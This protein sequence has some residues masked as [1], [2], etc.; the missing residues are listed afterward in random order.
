MGYNFSHL[1][2]FPPQSQVVHYLRVRYQKE[3]VGS[4]H[5]LSEAY[6][7]AGWSYENDQPESL[8]FFCRV[9]NIGVGRCFLW[10]RSV[11]P[12]KNRIEVCLGAG[13]VGGRC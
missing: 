13:V 12:G 9:P 6:C 8:S 11:P 10:P 4:Q 7:G 5:T 1:G 2:G 3:L